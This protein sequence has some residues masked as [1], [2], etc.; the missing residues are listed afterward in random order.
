MRLVTYDAGEGPRAGILRG[1]RVLGAFEGDLAALLRGP[2][3]DAI[4]ASGDGRAV[5]DVRL[6]APVLTPSKIVCLGLNYRSHA[7]EAGLE[8]PVTPTFFAKYPNALAP[9]DSEVPLPDYSQKVDYEAE[10]ALVIGRRSK[11]LAEEDALDA[12]AGYTLLNDLSARDYQF[13]TPQWQPGKVFDG[14]A[15]C[16]PA[17]V[18]PDEAGP[19]DAI[20]IRLDLNGRTMQS[21]STADL[22]HPIAAVVAY[23]SK[24]MTL[25]PGD[26]ISTGTPAG[27]GSVR[28]PRIWLQPGDEVVIESPTLG[29][30]ANRMGERSA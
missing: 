1:E 24:L 4:D 18:T 23:L 15:P 28:K 21:A 30:L 13:R 2:G 29:R 27:V 19:A 9:P 7:E 14:S 5:A 3:I 17:L 10:V 22:I 25:E 26:L 6:C 8:A 12:I 11:D 16:G 20:E